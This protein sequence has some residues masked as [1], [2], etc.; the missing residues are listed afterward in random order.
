[1]TDNQSHE[2]SDGITNVGHRER[3]CAALTQIEEQLVELSAHRDE[4]VDRLG[5]GELSY[6]D[7]GF[8]EQG[9]TIAYEQLLR[10]RESV[11][12]HLDSVNARIANLALRD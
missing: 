4:L 11:L 10:I 12:A 2:Y 8:E 6:I 3:L 5:S 7:F 9:A 1:M